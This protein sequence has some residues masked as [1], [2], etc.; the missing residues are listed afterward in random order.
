LDNSLIALGISNGSTGI[1]TD[2]AM[3]GQPK[4]AFPTVNGIEVRVLK[5]YC[6][7]NE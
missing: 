7:L 2:V 3:N 6:M 5:S 4:V 1:V